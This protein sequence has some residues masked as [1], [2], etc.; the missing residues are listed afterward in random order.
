[1]PSL[2]RFL[3]PELSGA[4]EKARE[5]FLAEYAVPAEVMS[6]CPFQKE[7]VLDLRFVPEY[8]LD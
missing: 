4:F 7:K 8:L 1:M 2:E 3:D 6:P 5:D